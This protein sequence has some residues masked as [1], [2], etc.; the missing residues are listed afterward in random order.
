GVGIRRFVVFDT[1]AF[2]L[3]IA[4]AMFATRFIST[5]E[6]PLSERDSLVIAAVALLPV[7]A[8]AA[9]LAPNQGSRDD[10]MG[11]LLG[12]GRKAMSDVDSAGRVDAE[13]LYYGAA[14]ALAAY[15][16]CS[17]AGLMIREPNGGASLYTI[18][19][20]GRQV[21]RLPPPSDETLVSRLL[22]IH[23][24]RIFGRRDDLGTRGL[25]DQYP[26]RLDSLV[27]APVPD[28]SG[29]GG[30]LFAVNRKGGF[31]ADDQLMADVIGR[32]VARLRL[33]AEAS[34]S[35]AELRSAATEALLA[36]TEA[37]RPG[38]RGQADECARFAMAIAREL[39]WSDDTI[40]ELRLAALLHDVGELALPDAILYKPEPLTPE[41]FEAIQVHPRAGAKMI[42]YF[43]RSELVLHAV[44]S[45]HEHWDGRGYPA[46]L[47]GND[48]PIAARV[49][50]LADAMETMLHPTPYR[51]ALTARDA[52]QEIVRLSGTHFDPSLVQVFLAMIGREGESFLGSTEQA[53]PPPPTARRYRGGR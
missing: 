11:R 52:I 40:E 21:D 39:E 34:T 36:A 50:T 24:A 25:P 17:I 12:S 30:T 45:H 41:E 43:N 35:V 22:G 33:T 48:I 27:A 46:G 5:F 49:L 28:V 13:H 6:L 23:E 44:H 2:S 31:R 14:S 19:G 26:P 37:R 3:L 4:V 47:A 10:P 16:E 20:E 38:S 42:D 1:F 32:E 53:A 18:A 9:T 29:P 8:R 7:L 15:A 51:P